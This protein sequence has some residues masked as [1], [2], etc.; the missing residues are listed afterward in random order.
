MNHLWMLTL[1]TAEGKWWV[2]EATELTVNGKRS[3]II[4]PDNADVCVKL[5]LL[6]FHVTD[7]VAPKALETFVKVNGI[8][9]GVLRAKGFAGI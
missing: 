3:V 6:P 9:S 4:D 8:T 1:K 2:V 7:G 5:H